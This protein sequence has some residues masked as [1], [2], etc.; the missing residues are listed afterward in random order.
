LQSFLTTLTISLNMAIKRTTLNFFQIV[1]KDTDRYSLDTIRI[2]LKDLKDKHFQPMHQ[3]GKISIIREVA[4]R[5]NCMLGAIF[6]I[7]MSNIPPSMNSQTLELQGLSL[8]DWDGLATATCFL[9][10]PQANILVIEAITGGVT[11]KGLCTYLKFNSSTLP[12]LE[13]AIIINPGQIQ[14]FYQMTSLY[15]FEARLAQV[16]DGSLFSDG[17]NT[18][19]SQ[20]IA[21]A[22]QTNTDKLTYKIEI[23]PENKKTDKSLNKSKI[24]NFVDRFL[25]YK[26]TNEVESLKVSGRIGDDSKITTLELIKERL[27]DSIEY[28]IEDRLIQSYNLQERFNQIEERYAHHRLSL[29]RTYKIADQD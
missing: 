13:P 7:Q 19:I 12:K 26:E 2:S 20:I 23:N 22:D 29:L 10:E 5:D 25:R 3:T 1:P 27:H 6:N 21:S 18:P 17:D 16:N 11:E 8:G 4:W 14:Q 9:I 24:S 15:Q 28:E